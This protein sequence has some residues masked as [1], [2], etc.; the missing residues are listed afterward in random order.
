MI[1]HR[2]TRHMN[3]EDR[4]KFLLAKGACPICELLL[5]SKYHTDCPYLIHHEEI[6]DN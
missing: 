4:M 1:D 6:V 3:K 5:V 2:K